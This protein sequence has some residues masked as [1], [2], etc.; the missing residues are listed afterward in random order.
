M[1]PPNR[2]VSINGSRARRRCHT[3]AAAASDCDGIQPSK[4]RSRPARELVQPGD[5]LDLRVAEQRE[6][7]RHQEGRDQQ[8]TEPVDVRRASWMVVTLEH[9]PRDG[10]TD[11]SE[12]DVEPELPLPRQ[13]SNEHRA[14]QRTPHPAERLDRAEHAERTP[15]CRSGYTSPTT[16]SATGTIAPPPMAVSTR[17]NRNGPSDDDVGMMIVPTMNSGVRGDER[18]PPA[19]DVADAAGDRHDRDERDEVGVD[20]PGGVIEAVGQRRARGRP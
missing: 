5:A 7:Q 4:I 17:P 9:P 19:D 20:D 11:D 3:N 16:A 18:A 6:V 13:E 15:R 12:R 1:R 14:V 8:A 2:R 10:H